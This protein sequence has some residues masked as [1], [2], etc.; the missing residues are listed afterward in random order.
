MHG[1][2]LS[3]LHEVIDPTG[4]PPFLGG[5]GPDLDIEGWKAKLLSTFGHGEDTHL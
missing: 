2:N 3:N 5:T 1:E 4:L